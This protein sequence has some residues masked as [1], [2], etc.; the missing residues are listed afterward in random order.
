MRIF[1]L[2]T[3]LLLGGCGSIRKTTTKR[4]AEEQLLLSSA[5]ERAITSIKTKKLQ[6][7]KVH[8]DFTYLSSLERGYVMSGMR[9]LC[10]ATGAEL[11]DERAKSDV[12]VEVRAVG[13]ANDDSH[14]SIGIPTL[15]A[16]GN[17]SEQSAEGSGAREKVPP[18]IE[19]GRILHEGWARVQGFAYE[20]ETGKFV[21]GWRNAWGYAHRGFFEDIYPKKTIG[22]TFRELF[23]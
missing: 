13:L 14:W 15:Y 12:I 23:R 8:V 19:I 5:A 1:L 9:E 17:S 4:S 2:L 11:V 22:Q 3:L 7:R 18:L 10:A 16:P 21:F 20:R 6:G